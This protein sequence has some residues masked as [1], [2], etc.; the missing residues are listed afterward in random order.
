MFSALAHPTSLWTWFGAVSWSACHFCPGF[1]LRGQAAAAPESV[2]ETW[3]TAAL[4]FPP[5]AEDSSGLWS[6]PAVLGSNEALVLDR[7][8]K[9]KTSPRLWNRHIQTHLGSLDATGKAFERGST[10][11]T[12]DGASGIVCGVEASWVPLFCRS[13]VLRDA[14][15]LVVGSQAYGRRLRGGAN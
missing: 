5:A 11:D 9:S 14:C 4:A 7:G 2:A 13:E 3:G 8:R 6:R 1:K 12:M 15:Y 10:V